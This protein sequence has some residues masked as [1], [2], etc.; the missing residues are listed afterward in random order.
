MYPDVK[1]VIGFKGGLGALV[2]F[3]MV[4]AG[5]LHAQLL[6]EHSLL[7]GIVQLGNVRLQLG[8]DGNDLAALFV[9]QLL[10]GH[11]VAALLGGVDLVLGEVGNVNGLFQGQQVGGV[12]RCPRL[13]VRNSL[14]RFPRGN[15]I[16]P[17]IMPMLDQERKRDP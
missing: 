8:A 2:P 14:L 10:H 11:I 15:A 12:E 7:L 4:Q 17:P 6:H 1:I 5:F 9:G 13:F 3:L 16:I